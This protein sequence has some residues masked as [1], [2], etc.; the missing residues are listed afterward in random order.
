[1]HLGVQDYPSLHRIR[2]ISSQMF[3]EGCQA[4]P[5]AVF[6]TDSQHDKAA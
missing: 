1:M 2:V 5:I 3:T 4:E 6:V